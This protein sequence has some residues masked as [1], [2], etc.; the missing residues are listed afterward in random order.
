MDHNFVAVQQALDADPALKTA[1]LVSISFDPVTD[2]PAVL[3]KHA[4]DL[5]ADAR[6]WTF[7]TGD[8]DEID[9]FASR[10]GMAIARSP[11][12]PVDITHSLR[13]AIVDADGK[14]VTLY[15]GNRWTPDQVV[16]DLKA[17]AR[18]Q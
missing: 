9:R 17:V 6:R 10:L 15:T 5:K 3:K 12:D 2:T 18:A 8:R 11:T 1:H 13:T 4:R 7:L 16:A 14:L